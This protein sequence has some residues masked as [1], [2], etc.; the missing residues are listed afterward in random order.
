ML[1]LTLQRECWWDR[2]GL[3]VFGCNLIGA[4]LGMKLCKGASREA[5][6]VAHSAALGVSH[7]SWRG[8][9]TDVKVPFDFA[10]FDW[11]S[12]SRMRNYLSSVALLTVLL[13]AELNVFFLK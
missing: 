5:C 1:H 8:R 11:R 9:R 13:S 7:F 6:D 10:A 3:D 2:W 12:V 4:W